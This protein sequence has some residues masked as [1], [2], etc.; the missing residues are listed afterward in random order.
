MPLP[1]RTA[2]TFF[3]FQLRFPTH[4]LSHTANFPNLKPLAHQINK[5]SWKSCQTQAVDTIPYFWQT[6][7]NIISVTNS[8]PATSVT[9]TVKTTFVTRT[10]DYTFNTTYTSQEIYRD[11]PHCW[12]FQSPLC[13]ENKSSENLKQLSGSNSTKLVHQKKHLDKKRANHRICL[14]C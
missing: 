5:I 2:M 7:F 12:H 4:K 10:P 11:N 9:T 6:T 13:S 14:K 8:E 1:C 3:I